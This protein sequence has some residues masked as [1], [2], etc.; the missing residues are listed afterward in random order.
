MD[1]HIA[2]IAQA[3]AGMRLTEYQRRVVLA[4]ARFTWNNW[5]RQT[6]K[7]YALTLRRLLR[8]IAWQR[9]QLML[10]ASGRQSRELMYKLREHCETLAHF[11]GQPWLDQIVFRTMELILP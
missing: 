10:S 2:W 9:T 8:G 4:P 11:F 6:G 5:A 7:S 3:V 1:K